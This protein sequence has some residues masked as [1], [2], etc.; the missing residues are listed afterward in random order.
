[1]LH[2]NSKVRFLLIWLF[3]F[4]AGAAY[5]YAQS[6]GGSIPLAPSSLRLDPLHTSSSIKLL[7][8]DNATNEDKFNIERKLSSGSAYT[9]LVQLGINSTSYTDASV[10]YEV[11]YDYRVQSCLSG[12]GCSEYSY[13]FGVRTLSNSTQVP[14]APTNVTGYFFQDSSSGPKVNMYWMDVANEDSYRVYQR[15]PGANSWTLAATY[16]ANVVSAQFGGFS[17]G[18]YTYYVTACSVN[19][20]SGESN[21]ITVIMGDTTLPTAPSTV[22]ATPFSSTR[23][24][25]AWS[26]AT[27]NVGVTSYKIFRSNAFLT[28]VSTLAYSDT[29]VATGTAYAYYIKAADAVGNESVPSLTV[30]VTTPVPAPTPTP[31]PTPTPSPSA[32]DTTLPTPPNQV[33]HTISA[34]QV[35]F[36]WGGATDNVA[37]AGYKIFR[38]GVY[39]VTKTDPSCTDSGLLPGT[40]Y[41]YYIKTFDAA[42]N[43]SVPTQTL[44]ITTLASST[45][46]VANATPTTTTT[47]TTTTPT[48]IQTST[49]STASSVLVS[50]T[51][52]RGISYCEGSVAKTPITF[53]ATPAG[54]AFFRVT[55]GTGDVLNDFISDTYAFPNG[56]YAWQAIARSGYTLSGGVR[57]SFVLNK[58]CT[59]ETTVTNT[60]TVAP[61]PAPA[62]VQKPAPTP[63]PT[64]I[65]AP[66]LQN[67][68]PLKTA[69]EPATVSV[70]TVSA[71][72]SGS[73]SSAS[74]QLFSLF[75]QAP[76]PD[77]IMTSE[78]YTHYCDDPAHQKECAQYAVKQISVPEAAPLSPTVTSEA[79]TAMQSQGVL[80]G[81]AVTPVELKA[82]CAQSAYAPS[83]ADL[84]VTAHVLNQEEANTHTAQILA[85]RKGEALVLTERVGAR[86]FQDS[87]SDGIT[88]YDEVNIYLTDPKK[89]D[90]NG[91]GVLDGQHLLL[92]TDPLLVVP[93]MPTST[94]QVS[95]TT[96]QPP[97]PVSSG[98]ITYEDP[99][100]S[101]DSKPDVVTVVNVKAIPVNSPDKGTTSIKLALSGSAL[102]NSFVTLFIFSDPIVVTVKADESG[103]WTYT[104]DKEL[105]D[106][107]HQVLSAITDG[108]GH[109]LAKS[110]PLPF[111]KQAFAISVGS[112][113]FT[114]QPEAPGFFS[115]G[116]LYALIAT[117]VGVF[118]LA[119]VLIGFV[120]RRR[121]S[122]QMSA[123]QAEDKENNLFP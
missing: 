57:D 21:M 62:P 25:L 65:V 32:A 64:P 118:A 56:T 2:L 53:K 49:T 96:S 108:G 80:P 69:T 114:A 40:S 111:V 34:T 75:A 54:G 87:D 103:A 39:L 86:M 22:T 1:M 90:T 12:S 73:T 68:V 38:N 20:C 29:G 52:S 84:Y 99:K 11:Y 98:K 37:V 5:V 107:T 106:G 41:S 15:A 3:L 36:T 117:L 92:G 102:P 28:S 110:A 66:T 26:G 89:G 13:L 8:N 24:D 63:A 35:S 47:D 78:Q 93:A 83:C 10:D 94:S 44:Y 18:T 116:S 112:P 6:A 77:T 51:V 74:S 122:E 109:I 97:A 79:F 113:L 115:G 88:D 19:G 91:D 60:T 95:T 42:G 105:P 120:V 7:W 48:P 67:T 119:L 33:S 72:S 27:D 14:A 50:A 30:N 16:G 58:T 55:K 81:G 23:I 85:L 82:V 46:S 31:T 100:F 101:G 45:E 76:A 9:F 17:G 4:G 59:T 71:P 123:P 104:L 70:E 121:P 61:T 43:E